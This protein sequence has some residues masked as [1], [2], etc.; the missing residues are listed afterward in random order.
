MRNR[1][2]LAAA[3]SFAVLGCSREFHHKATDEARLSARWE[4]DARISDPRAIM[5]DWYRA[6]LQGD[7]EVTTLEKTERVLLYTETHKIEK[8]ESVVRPVPL[9][10]LGAFA[11]LFYPISLALF[12]FGLSYCFEG[13]PDQADAVA[14][15]VVL[16]VLA[17]ILVPLAA[18]PVS[19]LVV[20]ALYGEVDYLP[21]HVTLFFCHAGIMVLLGV[22]SLLALLN[23][24]RTGL[25]FWKSLGVL[26]LLIEAAGM[27][28]TVRDLLGLVR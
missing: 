6:R 26:G 20:Y 25:P 1:L 8:A 27:V 9:Y 24:R 2:L 15:G 12:G 23:F 22:A 18:I 11:I 28:F 17:I 10:R 13:Q 7:V 19:K 3:L 21:W 5:P 16:A 4:A 14:G